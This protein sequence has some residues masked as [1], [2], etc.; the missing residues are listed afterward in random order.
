MKIEEGVWR[1]ALRDEQAR[2]DGPAPD[3]ASVWA[4]ATARSRS[5]RTIITAAVLAIVAFVAIGLPQTER[6]PDFVSVDDLMASTRWT[7]PSDTL[8]PQHQ[9][10]IY[11]EIPRLIESTDLT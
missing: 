1:K 2:V 6:H 5:V 7:A 4:A 8:L 11:Q 3:F 9:F 10:D